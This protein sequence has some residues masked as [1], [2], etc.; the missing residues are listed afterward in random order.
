MPEEIRELVREMGR[1]NNAPGRGRGRPMRLEPPEA[2]QLERLTLPLLAIAGELDFSYAASAARYLEERVP[3]ARAEVM[4]GV[5]HMIG[6]EAPEELARA[7]TAFVEPM[8]Y[9]S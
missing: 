7:I 9:R 4:P 6:L 2:E 8:A 3:S 1:E 5:A